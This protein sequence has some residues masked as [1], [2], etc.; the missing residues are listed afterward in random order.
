MNK[1]NYLTYLFSDK[2]A[3]PIWCFIL[4][5]LTVL[6]C[7]S[8][9][10][11]RQKNDIHEFELIGLMNFWSLGI[12]TIIFIGFY[13]TSYLNY[14]GQLSIKRNITENR[15]EN[16]EVEVYQ[17]SFTVKPI[18]QN[19]DAKINISPKV[20]IFEIYLASEYFLLL[21]CVREFGLF[22]MHLKPLLIERKGDNHRV[23]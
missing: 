20:E 6:S 5:G 23:N 12:L 1:S 22:R 17:D 13:T 19:Y 4:I 3:R 21:G 16:V 10:L 2:E 14:K 7:L 15:F 9:A 18:K 8:F 11:Y